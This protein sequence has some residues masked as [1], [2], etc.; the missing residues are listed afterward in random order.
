MVRDTY[1]ISLAAM[2]KYCNRCR[3]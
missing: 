1:L 3:M 2:F